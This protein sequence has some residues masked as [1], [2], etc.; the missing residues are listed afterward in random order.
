M[1]IVVFDS[2]MAAICAT[3]GR[4]RPQIG[5]GSVA[6]PTADTA[7]VAI[8]AIKHPRDRSLR[9]FAT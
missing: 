3:S 8:P 5:S 9:S 4:D 2:S 6:A 1:P 7:T